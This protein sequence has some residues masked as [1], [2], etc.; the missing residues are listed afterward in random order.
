MTV[1][2]INKYLVRLIHS[3]E[4]I[5]YLGENNRWVQDAKN[6][7]PF[8]STDEAIE[9]GNGYNFVVITQIFFERI[10]EGIRVTV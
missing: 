10:E 3:S 9:A 1:K 2:L 6:A 7:K 5:L 4:P 8:N